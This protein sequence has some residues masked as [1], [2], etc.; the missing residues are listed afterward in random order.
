[1]GETRLKIAMDM[2]GWDYAELSFEARIVD[3]SVRRYVDGI[4]QPSAGKIKQFAEALRVSADFLVGLTDD[5]TPYWLSEEER[6]IP[7]DSLGPQIEEAAETTAQ[8]LEGSERRHDPEQ[9]LP[10]GH[11]RSD[12]LP[13]S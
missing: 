6:P 13:P 7:P 11:R 10:G 4:T 2:R 1:M 5:P 3:R 12:P 9:P 8:E